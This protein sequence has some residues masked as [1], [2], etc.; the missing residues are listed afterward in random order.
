MNPGFQ[1]L[2]QSA[3]QAPKGT[4][5]AGKIRH[6]LHFWQCRFRAAA[7]TIAGM[8]KEAERKKARAENMAEEAT[9]KPA[10]KAGS[11]GAQ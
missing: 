2:S 7:D 6:A 3:W 11:A 9:I 5:P 8:E 4:G 10:V 1:A